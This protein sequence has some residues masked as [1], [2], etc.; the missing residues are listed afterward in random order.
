MHE[1][2]PQAQNAIKKA[3]VGK[4]TGIMIMS[5]LLSR[6]LGILRDTIM[7][8]QFGRGDATDAYVLAFQIPD[9]L[10]FLIAGGAL[11]SAFIPVF[12][13]YL[14]TDKKE[15]AWKVFS[16][17]VTIMS[18][19]LLVFIALNMIFTPQLVALMN[20]PEKASLFPL[21]SQ[22][23]RILVPA[24]FAFFVGG[25]MFGTLYAH[26]RFS[27]PGLGPNIYNLGIIFGAVV[28]SHFVS[29][30]IVGMAYGGLVGAM[31][32]NLVI[33]IFEMKRIGAKFTPGFNFDHPGVRKVF[34]LMLPV[35]LGLSLPGV[36]AMIM[37]YL[38]SEFGSGVVTTLDLS[39]KLMQ[40]PLGIF[41]QSFAIAVF[42][43]LSKLYA[44]K[45]MD[46]FRGQLSSTLC[47][48]LYITIPIA[49]ILAVLSSDIVAALYQYGKFTAADSASVSSCLVLFCIGIPAWCL[50]P[51][52]MRGYFAM[53]NTW[54]PIAVGTAT[55]FVFVGFG[56]AFSHSPM[57]YLGLPLAS[58]ISAIL[59]ALTLIILVSKDSGGMEI[60]PFL[61]VFFKSLLGG[62]CAAA[63]AYA[64]FHF[65]PTGNMGLGRNVSAILR[66][67]VIGCSAMWVHLL[68]TRKMGMKEAAIMEKVEAKLSRKKP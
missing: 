10:F 6:I 40:A 12:S 48:T 35:I 67:L 24:Q 17:V 51:I 68:V 53:Q 61:L 46:K 63:A 27:I 34:K 37:R 3:S 32:G 36:Y 30:G 19:F 39:N 23:S 8:S 25:L 58:S 60:E 52:L 26:Q 54:K 21:I 47:Q 33:P 22:M 13:E 7:V 38:G 64:L 14:H 41:G 59:M 55:T 50:H 43:E 15:E 1:T 29:P 9:L 16:S 62:L 57:S 20:K 18:A 65:L 56:Y 45:S 28:I 49:A 42:P 5:L 4:A 44:E 66:V 2:V 31:I 11:S